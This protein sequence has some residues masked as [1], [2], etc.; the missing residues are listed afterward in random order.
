M[1]KFQVKGES[2]LIEGHVLDVSRPALL[3]ALRRYDPLL[4]VKWNSK[5]RAG[6][7][8][9]ELRRRPEF[10]SVKEGRY[11]DSP[12][13]RVFMPGDVFEFD[14]Y[15]I[16][17][18]KYNENN[19]ENHVKDFEYLTYDMVS[20]LASHDL[21]KYGFKG[22]N[23]MRDAEYNEAKYLDKIDEEADAERQYMIK[24][25]KTQF[26]DFRQYIAAGGNPYRLMDYWD[27][28]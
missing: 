12:R 3:A 8:C 9:W 2:K 24:Q 23:T 13:G 4:Y 18:P 25:H 22:K 10:K 14:G 6:K 11:L 5:K 1:P 15:T 26:Q 7:G 21:W 17:I 19:F 27:K 20:W 16:S 28:V